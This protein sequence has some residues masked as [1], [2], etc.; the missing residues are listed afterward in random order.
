ME[1]VGITPSEQLAGKKNLLRSQ[2]EI[3]SIVRRYQK[4]KQYRKEEL[5]LKSIFRKKI[6]EVNEEFKIIE[7]LM[8]RTH[9]EQRI[10]QANKNLEIS[11][12]KK[13]DLEAEIEEIRRK[14]ESLQ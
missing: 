9:V 14:L 2:M 8:P 7:R 10:E 13:Y 11:A 3:L 12:K 1:Y 4:Y 6:L 5:A